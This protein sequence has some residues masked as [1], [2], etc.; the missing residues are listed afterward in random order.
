MVVECKLLDGPEEGVGVTE[1]A[2]CWC[3]SSRFRFRFDRNNPSRWEVS[4]FQGLTCTILFTV[5][6]LSYVM[7]VLLH[8]VISF[9]AKMQGKKVRSSKPTLDCCTEKTLEISFFWAIKTLAMNFGE[10]KCWQI[11]LNATVQISFGGQFNHK[12][13][14][15]VFL[16]DLQA[17]Q[18]VDLACL[19]ALENFF[20]KAT[21]SSW[22][23][24]WQWLPLQRLFLQEKFSSW[25]IVNDHGQGKNFLEIQNQQ[26]WKSKIHHPNFLRN[27]VQ[28]CCAVN[29]SDS[30]NDNAPTIGQL[31][32]LAMALHFLLMAIRQRW[33]KPKVVS[34]PA[35]FLATFD[36]WWN[37]SVSDDKAKQEETD[38]TK[39]KFMT[40]KGTVMTTRTTSKASTTRVRVTVRTKMMMTLGRSAWSEV[41]WDNDWRQQHGT[42]Q[43]WFDADNGFRQTKMLMDQASH[44]TK[45]PGCTLCHQGV[46]G[47]TVGRGK[48]KDDKFV[49]KRILCQQEGYFCAENDTTEREF[50]IIRFTVSKSKKPPKWMGSSFRSGS[51]WLWYDHNN[52]EQRCLDPTTT[53]SHG[54]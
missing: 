1:W 30:H 42:T 54:Y 23:A 50:L 19:C 52:Q 17:L 21:P 34:L 32:F 53:Y 48:Q 20:M 47:V 26:N 5:V 37:K 39:R 8:F 13:P 9:S 51:C 6:S 46:C 43:E 31:M 35:A 45:K 16:T 36:K 4:T 38:V 41:T 3:H 49:W 2:Y 27:W 44:S 11:L 28:Q 15:C 7:L 40:G 24:S 25:I 18:F 10:E 12:M 14:K 33:H 29:A 22:K